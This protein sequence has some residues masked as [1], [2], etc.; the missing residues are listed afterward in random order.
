VLRYVSASS[1]A[2]AGHALRLGETAKPLHRVFGSAR[3]KTYLVFWNTENGDTPWAL[4]MEPTDEA[5]AVHVT[6]EGGQTQR[7]TIVR[8]P[9]PQGPGTA[10][11]YLCPTLNRT[12]TPWTP[13]SQ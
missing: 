13:F 8:R 2:C 6:L 12:R 11:F 10:F 7:L 1:R 4:K 3:W 9:L 5:D